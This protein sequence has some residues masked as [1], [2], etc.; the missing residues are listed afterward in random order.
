LGK[1]R[2]TLPKLALIIALAE[3][4]N[5]ESISLSAY[6]RAEGLLEFFYQH[7][8]RI[9]SIVARYEISS[10]YELLDRIRKG[11]LPDGFN[12]RD[13]IQRKEWQGL[14]TSGEIEA[15]LGLLEKHGYVKIVEEPTSGRPKRIVRIN[16]EITLQRG[17]E[18][19]A[20]P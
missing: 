10:A 1:F 2:G 9:Y 17:T 13:D 19:V 3:D 11:Q 20:P 18:V 5:T 16:P 7:A 4:P 12:P 14:R 6:R 15:A 8:K